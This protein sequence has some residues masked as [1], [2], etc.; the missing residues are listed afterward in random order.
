MSF[1]NQ[2]GMAGK[3]SPLTYRDSGTL[4]IRSG[5]GCLSVFGL[6]FLLA[7]LFVMQI[8]LGLI[9][10]EGS[11]RGPCFSI[12]SSCLAPCS[13]PS[14]PVSSSGAA[15]SSWTAAGVGSFSGGGFSCP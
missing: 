1:F 4:E 14:G 5:G 9:P 11:P 3:K 7:G 8:P 6:P 10:V 12:L 13:P 15:G 2:A